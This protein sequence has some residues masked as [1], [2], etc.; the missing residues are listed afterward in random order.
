MGAPSSRGVGALALILLGLPAA[1]PGQQP[2]PVFAVGADIVNVTVTV[3][4]KSGRLVSDLRPE[5]FLVLEDGRP[6]SVQVFARA[7]DPGQEE[8]LT[9]DL[10][11]LL[12]TSGSMLEVLRLSQEAAIRFLEAIPRARDLLTIFFD[13]D[14]RISRYDNEH[15]QGLF[16]RILEAQGGGNTALYDAI[17]VYISRVQDSSG[18]KVLVLFTDGEDTTSALGMTDLMKLVKSS[19]VTIYSIAFTGGMA[20]GSSRALKSKIVLMQLAEATGGAVF[21]PMASR[22]LAGVY[23]RIL[24]ELSGQYV[25]GFYSDNTKHD[26]KYRKLKVQLAREGLSLRHRPGY[27]APSDDSPR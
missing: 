12:D 26:G 27:H 21:S 19:T 16:E 10:G 7:V 13:Q 9:L 25:L 17:A 22:D 8:T 14:I 20:P 18:R 4:D 11:L 6:Q 5:D 3:R 1:A 24:D 2:A 15:Q 23:R